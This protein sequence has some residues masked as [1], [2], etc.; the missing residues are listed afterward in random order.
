M[1][2]SSRAA[3][4]A[5]ASVVMTFAL[6]ATA[7]AAAPVA[8]TTGS[9]SITSG[10]ATLVGTVDPNNEATTYYF[11]YGTTRRYGSRTEAVGPIRGANARRVTAR[12]EGLAPFT[13]HHFRLVASNPS[14][15]DSGEN[16]SFRTLRQPLGLQ[17]NAAP[18]PVTFGQPTTIGGTLTGTGNANRQVVLQQR[19]FPY[20]AAFTNVGN[21]LVTDAAGNFSFPILPPLVNTQYQVSTVGDNPVTSGIVSLGVAVRV[22]TKRSARRVRRNRT[23]RLYGRMYPGR[24][25]TRF[26]VQKQTRS[27]RWMVVARGLTTRGRNGY[28]RWSKRIKVPRSARYRVVIDPRDGDIV[29][30]IGREV[31]VRVRG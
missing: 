11:E 7:M 4:T 26:Q 21:P 16:R 28:G 17:I 23:V 29:A 5:L 30:G 19:P 24:R 9:N 6:A 15:V 31:T 25:L 1:K 13:R 10:G 3:L 22:V 18:N 2:L 8:R 14:G 12:V 27:G 20:T